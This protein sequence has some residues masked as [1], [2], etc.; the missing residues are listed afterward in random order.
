MK[1]L[2]CGR[3]TGGDQV[4]C[5]LCTQDMQKDPVKPGTAVLLPNRPAQQRKPRVQEPS[6]EEKL[7]RLRHRLRTL[8]LI[9]LAA[10]AVIAVLACLL[11]FGSEQ[12]QDAQP[13]GRNFGGTHQTGG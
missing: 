7:S 2:R 12:A 6:P 10:I 11:L 13:L 8:R 3:D 9:L 4:F 1:C 5:T